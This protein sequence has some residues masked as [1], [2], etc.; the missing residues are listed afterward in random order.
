MAN[1][2]IA[3]LTVHP[4]ARD[5]R[6]EL[7]RIGVT[8]VEHRY[9]EGFGCHAFLV[10]AEDAERALAHLRRT[11]LVQLR[12]AEL[13]AAL[14]AG[15]AVYRYRRHLLD[16]AEDLVASW[17]VVLE[18]AEGHLMRGILSLGIITAGE[19]YEAEE[20]PSLIGRELVPN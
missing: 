19:V 11:G 5:I 3:A 15:N 1:M 2:R 20:I 10:P 13:V 16:L 18:T 4:D 8:E 14:H 12:E 17:R 7:K 9:S 6:E